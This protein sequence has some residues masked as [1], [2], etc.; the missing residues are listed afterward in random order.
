M[1]MDLGRTSAPCTTMV[2]S[3]HDLPLNRVT[4]VSYPGDSQEH[5]SVQDLEI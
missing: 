3:H 1:G 4:H 5:L 2:W